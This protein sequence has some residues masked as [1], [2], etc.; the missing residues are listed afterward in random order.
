MCLWPMPRAPPWA[1][2]AS[3]AAFDGSESGKGKGA[4]VG[5]KGSIL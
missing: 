3:A 4:G 5:A 2:W 1:L